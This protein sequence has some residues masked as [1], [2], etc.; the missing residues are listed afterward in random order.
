MTSRLLDL[1]YVLPNLEN[2]RCYRRARI[3]AEM[4]KRKV[5]ALLLF[6]PLNIRYATD[7]SN[8]QLWTSHNLARAVLVTIDG[9]VIFWDFAKCQHMAEHLHRINEVRTVAGSFYFEFGDSSEKQAKSFCQEVRDALLQRNISGP[10]GIDRMDTDIAK[11]FFETGLKIVAGQTVMEHARVIKSA[12]E[13]LAMRCA[14]A[15]CKMAMAEMEKV[16]Q[17]GMAEVELWSVLHKENIAQGG[18]WIE[19]R[20]LSSGPRTNPW[21]REASGRIMKAGEIMA[22]DTDLIGLFGICVDT[23]RTWLVGDIDANAAQIEMYQIAHEHIETNQ[24]LLAPGVPMRDLTFKGHVLPGAY[25]A[26]KYC[27]KMHGV[28]LCDEFPSIYYPDNYI[29][30]AFDYHL[31]PGMVLC[32]EAYVGKDDGIEGIKLENQVLVT[33]TGF[34]NLTTYPYDERLLG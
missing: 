4:E 1:G 34:E 31:E 30:G 9:H 19:T 22:F 25:Q 13:I 27:V 20:L 15:G 14:V 12:D 32:V 11:A 23:S 10:I 6:D 33:D 8:M 21:M 24:S 5:D 17:P 3:L 2:I 28:G 26:K 18:E 29:E 16:M 7:S